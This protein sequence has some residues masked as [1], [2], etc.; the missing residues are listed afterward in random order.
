ML[1]FVAA[2]KEELAP[3]LAAASIRKEEVRGGRSFLLGEVWGCEAVLVVSNP[4]KVAAA[5][6]TTTLLECF[7]V[8]ELFVLGFC[9]ALFPTLRRG[10]VLVATELWQHDVR[11]SKRFEPFE[12]PFSGRR[13]FDTEAQRRG[14]LSGLGPTAGIEGK[15]VLG[16]L[17]TGDEFVSGEE[18]KARVREALPHAMAV[19]MESAAVGQ[20]A[21]EHGVPVTV[22][23]VVSDGCGPDAL[24]DLL[25][26]QS[27]RAIGGACTAL[28]HALLG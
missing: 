4:C 25:R 24:D 10:D 11:P 18:A 15:V 21:H 23:R 26:S 17:A 13:W 9:G 1:G 14:A 8:T 27:D 12:I 3:L 20:V 5:T 19:D 7:G 22:L 28:L 2:L 6:T 16:P